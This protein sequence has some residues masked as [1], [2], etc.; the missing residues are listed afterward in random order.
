MD[1]AAQHKIWVTQLKVLKESVSELSETKPKNVLQHFFLQ[2]A[3]NELATDSEYV[4]TMSKRMLYYGLE[5]AGNMTGSPRHRAASVLRHF[6]TEPIIQNVN[7]SDLRN[8][9]VFEIYKRCGI[10]VDTYFERYSSPPGSAEQNTV[11]SHMAHGH[12]LATADTT[13][14][15]DNLLLY[16]QILKRFF[17]VFDHVFHNSPMSSLTLN[18]I[19]GMWTS[20]VQ[21]KGMGDLVWELFLDV[22]V[23][24]NL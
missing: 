5:H 14:I 23:Y 10:T 17:V 7:L 18:W 15:L 24:E 22:Y 9:A 11:Y 6:M 12:A 21:E 3:K 19:G 1:C 8:I 13:V 20:H 2:A 16:M 4:K